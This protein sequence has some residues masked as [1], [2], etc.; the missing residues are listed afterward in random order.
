MVHLELFN[1]VP[2]QQEGNDKKQPPERELTEELIMTPQGFLRAYSAMERLVKQ[3]TEAG[4]VSKRQPAGNAN[5]GAG[6]AS[7]NFQVDK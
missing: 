4:I 3:L 7:P 1:F 6:N 2:N 5:T